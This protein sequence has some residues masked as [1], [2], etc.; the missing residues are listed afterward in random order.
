MCEIML[1]LNMQTKYWIKRER[2]SVCVCVSDWCVFLK[3]FSIYF[4]FCKNERKCPFF[5]NCK[6]GKR[7][8]VK[9][10]K[11]FLIHCWINSGRDSG[12]WNSDCNC[13][14]NCFSGIF[15][16]RILIVVVDVKLF[17]LRI[18]SHFPTRG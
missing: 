8:R 13:P 17:A 11:I 10:T 7:K 5:L 18:S 16:L 1:S 6:H 12:C 4:H 2:V 14:L 9:I 3:I 15:I